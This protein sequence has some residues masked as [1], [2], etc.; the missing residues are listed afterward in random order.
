M[1]ERSGVSRFEVRE[2][3]GRGGGGTV[4]R[5]FDRE[6]GIEVAVK[7]LHSASQAH[8]TALRRE[9]RLLR[10]LD[11]PGIVL[12]LE[13][14][15]DAD[16]LFLVSPV[17]EGESFVAHCRGSRVRL[18]SALPQLLSVLRYLHE[19]EIAHGDLSPANVLVGA[20]GRVSVIDFGLSGRADDPRAARGGTP[21]YVAPE[22][23][24]GGLPTPE[25]DLFSLGRL[26]ADCVPSAMLEPFSSLLA[27]APDVRP[28]AARLEE[29]LL[30]RLGTVAAST[31]SMLD[32]SALVGRDALR[33][34]IARV[35]LG[36]RSQLLVGVSAIGK[37]VLLDAV[38]AD[39]DGRTVLRARPRPGSRVP[40]EVVDELLEDVDVEVDASVAERLGRHASSMAARTGQST[41]ALRTRAELQ[42]RL[43]GTRPEP[44]VAEDV[45]TVLAQVVDPV[46]VVDDLQWA[47]ADSKACLVELVERFDVCVLAAARPGHVFPAARVEVGPLAPHA[48]HELLRAR[49]LDSDAADAIASAADGIPGIAVLAAR[50][51][52]GARP[53]DEA[54]AEAVHALPDGE[55]E[56][57]AALHVAGRPVGSDSLEHASLAALTLKGLVVKVRDRFD[58]AHDVLREPIGR[59]LG[60]DWLRS[61]RLAR[62]V[63]PH[64]PAM[65][66]VDAYLALGEV[67]R[68]AEV[69]RDAAHE[70]F[71]LGAFRASADLWAIVAR[72]DPDARVSLARALVA[73]GRYDDAATLWADLARDTTGAERRAH[74]LARAHSAFGARR[75]TE[76]TEALRDALGHP[77]PAWRTIARFLRGPRDEASTLDPEGAE[78]AL[79]NAALAGYYESVE[80]VR[81]ALDA[82]AAFGPNTEDL[83]AWA[84][85]LLAFFARFAGMPRL[86]RQYRRAGARWKTG[87][88]QP[89]VTAFPGFLDG[90][91][92][93][94]AGRTR[95]A[96]RHFD[97]SLSEV[98]GTVD[99]TSFEVRLVLS[100]RTSAVI[101]SQRVAAVRAAIARFE[102][103]TRRSA[104][105]A[106]HVHVETARALCSTWQGRYE[107]AVERL[108]RARGEWA[109]HPDTIQHVLIE[110][111]AAW[112]RSLLGDACAAH[113][114]LERALRGR[115][116][117]L[118]SAYGPIL[119][120]F[121]ASTELAAFREGHRTAS[122]ARALARAL[123][124]R[125]RPSF[126]RGI[127]HR[128]AASITGRG[129]EAAERSAER[130]DQPI[131]RA[132]ARY[133]RGERVGGSEGAGLCADA[134]RWLADAGAS[135]RLFEEFRSS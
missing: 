12:P 49:G 37:T 97:Q 120:A 116:L 104:N 102:A 54:L 75:I 57:L 51:A 69:A 38:V 125:R 112:P 86:A 27:G 20:D 31:P 108:A 47:D 100:L 89:I 127:A 18:G 72:V 40:F 8:E 129:W 16:G 41:H 84:D 95:D 21:G 98:D 70:A 105:D 23:A 110:A 93:L 114:D 53:L 32:R 55:R 17:V 30:P 80:G 66:R 118:G 128:V 6:R 79:R 73:A 96:I 78:L 121:A 9:H 42:A 103:A 2:T 10:E 90:Y 60:D 91:D 58:I 56:A 67:E 76:G 28:S 25:A 26:L 117:L 115:T 107:H 59:A 48:M 124:A 14:G 5:A 19:R 1:D 52:R 130:D 101:K 62:A 61:A 134:R 64:V 34:R 123:L 36:S 45:A 119:L 82:R 22:R 33:R 68:A 92:H 35:A 71:E 4:V 133:A 43:F 88:P 122:R 132:L 63:E 11:H 13:I 94:R 77:A 7:R 29:E 106:L 135:P 44:S 74:T 126:A 24:A 50:F 111:Y 83:G 109:A 39:L 87:E 65:A 131:D 15:R 3:L 99:E 85:H 113:D 81:L 46:L